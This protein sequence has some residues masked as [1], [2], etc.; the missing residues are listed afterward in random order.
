VALE[1][2]AFLKPQPV[3]EVAL[4]HRIR[5]DILMVHRHMWTSWDAS[6]SPVEMIERFER[7]R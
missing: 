2:F 1:V 5:V 7:I 6:P 4:R 3:T